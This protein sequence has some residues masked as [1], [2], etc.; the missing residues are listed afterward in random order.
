MR[1]PH[2]YERTVPRLRRE[3][4]HVPDS[5]PGQAARSVVRGLPAL[6]ALA[7]TAGLTTLVERLDAARIEAERVGHAQPES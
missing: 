5:D 3:G 6:I 4:Y 1:R 2:V 7:E